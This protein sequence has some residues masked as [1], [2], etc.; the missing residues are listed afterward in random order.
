MNMSTLLDIGLLLVAAKI[1][2]L[3]LGRLGLHTAVACTLAGAVVGPLAGIVEPTGAIPLLLVVG[4]VVFF[5][6]VGLDE[7]DV[8]GFMAAARGR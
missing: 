8:P 2:Q 4:A 5:F 1:A 6:L 7:I 3:G